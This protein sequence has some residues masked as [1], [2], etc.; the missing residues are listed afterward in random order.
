MLNISKEILNQD[1]E[2]IYYSGKVRNSKQLLPMA[3]R[4]GGKRPHD[5]RGL[6]L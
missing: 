2:H 6:N 4:E 3:I 1:Y 5:S